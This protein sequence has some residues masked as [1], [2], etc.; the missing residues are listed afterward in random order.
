MFIHYRLQPSEID[1]L[2]YYRFET[3]IE[4]LLEKLKAE[5]KQNNDSKAQYKQPKMP[6]MKMPNM[7][8]MR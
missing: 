2:D 6:N 3:Y 4:L 7:P 5:E 1:N 8:K